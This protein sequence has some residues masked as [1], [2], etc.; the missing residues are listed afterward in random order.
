MPDL[1]RELAIADRLP[2]RNF[3]K[4]LP[5]PLLKG[6]AAHMEREPQSAL[7]LLDESDN[8]RDHAIEGRVAGHELGARKSILQITHE[9]VGII[10]EQDGAHT[11]VRR[12]HQ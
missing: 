10:T 2:W 9:S 7:G 4:R 6:G 5:D 1:P 12:R 8:H 3:T 11:F